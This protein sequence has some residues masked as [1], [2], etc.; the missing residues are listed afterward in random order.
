MLAK[1]FEG[2][3]A[4]VTGGASGIGRATALMFAREGAKVVVAD[5]SDAAGQATCEAII[6]GGGEAAYIH[7]DVTQAGDVEAMVGLAVERFGRLDCAFNSAGIANGS[8]S[9]G[10]FLAAD[11][12]EADWRRII[13]VN[14]TGAWLSMKYEIEQM[15]RGDGGT[16]VNAASVAGLTGLPMASAYV[17]SKHGVVGLTKTAALEYAQQGIRVNCVCPGYIETPMTARG[18]SNP[19]R[20]AAMIA[21]KPMGRLGQPEEVAESVIWLCSEATSFVT[22]HTMTIDGGYFA[23]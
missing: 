2:K 12:P 17:A 16:I 15:L 7:V 21:S 13:D 19:E 11:C 10:S 14:L 1:A 6:A 8:A 4:V 9:G 5:V 3:V 23:K 18:R 22:G 20:L